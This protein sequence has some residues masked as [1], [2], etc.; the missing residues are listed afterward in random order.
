MGDVYIPNTF[1]PNKD[2]KNE[3]WFI[4]GYCVKQIDCIIFNRWGEYVA[5]LDNANS[6]WDGIYNGQLV[7]EGIYVY[8]ALITFYSNDT[9]SQMGHILISY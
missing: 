3:N 2:N 4:S 1:T 8:S 7:Q 5:R 6:S 9:K